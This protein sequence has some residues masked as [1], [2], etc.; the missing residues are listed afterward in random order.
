LFIFFNV[1]K[2]VFKK[3]EKNVVGTIRDKQSSQTSTLCLHK[4]FETTTIT[5]EI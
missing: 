1:L 4:Q 5:F 3:Y 2:Y